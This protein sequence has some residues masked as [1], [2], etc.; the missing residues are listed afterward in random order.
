MPTRAIIPWEAGIVLN[1]RIP[2]V[3]IMENSRLNDMLTRYGEVCTQKTAAQLLNIVPRTVARMCDEGRLR[4][5]GHRVDVR[6][7]YEYITNP[8]LANFETR[9]KAA[10]PRSDI[11]D[12]EFFAAAKRGKWKANA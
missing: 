4:R 9:V 3:Y 12:G 11:S 7:I 10:H 2:E 6:S 5:V 8:R 1:N